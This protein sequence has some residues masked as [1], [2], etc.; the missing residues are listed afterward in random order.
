MLF[1][2]GIQKILLKHLSNCEDNPE[3]AFSPDG[4][5]LMNRTILELNDNVPHKPIH[6]VRWYEKSDKFAV[7]ATGQKSKKFV[8]AAKGTNLFYGI[9]EAEYTDKE[10][11]EIRYKRVYATIPLNEVIA[12][13]KEGNPSVPLND[14]EGNKLL[15]SLSPG[16]LVYVPTKEQI[17]KELTKYDINKERIYKLVSVTGN[18]SFFI[19]SKVAT[20]II[21][22]KEFSALNKLARAITDEMIKEVCIPIKLDRLGNITNI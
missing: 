10:S 15:F 17:G 16:D 21:D 22:K 5:D 8:E 1:R 7:G 18:E 9:Y 19:L 11:G 13:Q 2:S 4:I 20:S 3:I 12:R 14:T 6:K